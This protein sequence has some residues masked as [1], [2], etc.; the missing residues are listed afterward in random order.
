LC[1]CYIRDCFP[2]QNG[3]LSG[4]TLPPQLVYPSLSRTFSDHAPPFW[5][6]SC[7][8]S[9][10]LVAN[11]FSWFPRLLGML[12]DFYSRVGCLF[13]G[14]H[15]F[16]PGP[17]RTRTSSS[18][19]LAGRLCSPGFFVPSYVAKSPGVCSFSLVF[20][21]LQKC[22]LIPPMSFFPVCARN[23]LPLPHIFPMI[24][25]MMGVDWRLGSG[26]WSPWVPVSLFT[27]PCFDPLLYMMLSS[28]TSVPVSLLG[29]A[30]VIFYTPQLHQ[31]P[32]FRLPPA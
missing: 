27:K 13:I 19:P 6:A 11:F 32:F 7:L 24:F 21:I 2:S 5:S 14:N 22:R 31:R 15:V 9:I 30:S 28:V 29:R 1:S 20:L 12:F 4:C 16:C 25:S 23:S 8:L 10:F 26:V 18:S 3:D 17:S